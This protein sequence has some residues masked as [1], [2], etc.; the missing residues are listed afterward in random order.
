MTTNGNSFLRRWAAIAALLALTGCAAYPAE[1][2]GYATG[3]YDGPSYEGLYGY[4]GF[5]IADWGSYPHFYHDGRWGHAGWDQHGAA[6]H[7][8]F[9]HPQFAWHG[10][11]GGL[12]RGI[13][14]PHG[15][16]AHIGMAGHGGGARG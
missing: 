14:A 8:G 12:Q 9:V 1:P 2:G 10:A 3:Y 11:A 7:E 16:F 15:G 13:G 4:N 6:Q 5:G